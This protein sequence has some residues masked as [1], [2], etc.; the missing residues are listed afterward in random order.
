MTLYYVTMSGWHP[1]IA[2]EFTYMY[3]K[4]VSKEINLRWYKDV[5]TKNVE[6]KFANMPSIYCAWI[7]QIG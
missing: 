7:N 6:S 2:G 3:S 4:D 1:L 5:E